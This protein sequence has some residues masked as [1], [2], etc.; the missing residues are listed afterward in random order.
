MCC[1]KPSGLYG[2]CFR[3]V[4]QFDTKAFHRNITNFSTERIANRGEIDYLP[5]SYSVIMVRFFP[6]HPQHGLSC[7]NRNEERN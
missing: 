1:S 5:S 3:V 4:Y 6:V 7:R 2:Y